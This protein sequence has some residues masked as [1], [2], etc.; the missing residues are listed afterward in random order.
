[1]RI[2]QKTFGGE[3][4]L[5]TGKGSG[6]KPLPVENINIDAAT[7]AALK[8]ALQDEYKARATYNKVIE[9]FG[10]VRPFINIVEAENR[11]ANALLQQFER[12]GLTPPEDEWDGRVAAPES[13]TAACEAAFAAELE[14]DAM[15]ERS[16]KVVDDPVIR[17]VFCNLRDAS[18]YRHLPALRRCKSRWRN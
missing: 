18:R 8:E 16:L 15:Y 14:N 12:L 6:N 10:R 17:A 7:V 1:M 2:Q 3:Q 13:L 5:Q 11:H 4:G 9:I